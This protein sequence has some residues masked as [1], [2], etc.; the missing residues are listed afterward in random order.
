ME[1]DRPEVV[2]GTGGRR[3]WE[4]GDSLIEYGGEG[5]HPARAVVVLRGRGGL[6]KVAGGAWGG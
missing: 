4:L 1:H 6:R 5:D 2:G 3:R